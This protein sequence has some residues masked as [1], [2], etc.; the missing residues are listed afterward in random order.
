[1]PSDTPHRTQ[2]LP[3]AMCAP[4]L[5]L[6]PSAWDSWHRVKS[7]VAHLVPGTAS[8]GSLGHILNPLGIS[9]LAVTRKQ[10]S[11]GSPGGRVLALHA[12]GPGPI[13]SI[14]HGP[15]ST[16][17]CCPNT[18]KR[19]KSGIKRG[20]WQPW[21]CSRSFPPP[22]P[23]LPRPAECPDQPLCSTGHAAVLCRGVRV[24]VPG[25]HQR[26]VRGLRRGGGSIWA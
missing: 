4:G 19:N 25:L 24:H 7:A 2:C 20:E 1:M 6:G 16:A 3:K 13:S 11:R 5:C 12:T 21:G 15:L 10:A 14:P 8:A 23:G 17:R 9:G 22:T 18:R 26:R